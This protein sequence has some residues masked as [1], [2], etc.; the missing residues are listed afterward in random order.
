MFVNHCATTYLVYHLLS[1]SVFVR[2]DTYDDVKAVGTFDDMG[3]KAD[4]LKGI[5]QYGAYWEISFC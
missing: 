5:Y 2:L 1:Y 3:L 4:L